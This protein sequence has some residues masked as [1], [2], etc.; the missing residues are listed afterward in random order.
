MDDFGLRD[1]RLERIEAV[2]PRAATWGAL[3]TF[4]G[5]LIVAVAAFFG[6]GSQGQR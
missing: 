5:G 6:V 3:G 1:R 2:G 4:V